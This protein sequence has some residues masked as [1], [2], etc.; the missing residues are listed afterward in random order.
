MIGWLYSVYLPDLIFTI[1]EAPLGGQKKDPRLAAT[2]SAWSEA[3][4]VSVARSTKEE[5]NE[6]NQ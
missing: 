6:T 1:E 4:Q 3:R 2:M 5:L